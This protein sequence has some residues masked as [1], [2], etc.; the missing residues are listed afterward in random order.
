MFCRP[1]EKPTSHPP[2][3]AQ[4]TAAPSTPVPAVYPTLSAPAPTAAAPDP[5]TPTRGWEEPTTVQAPTWDDEPVQPAVTS[6]PEAWPPATEP[7]SKLPSDE[8]KDE[9][10]PVV[11]A[12]PKEVEPS[13]PA[14]EP[15]VEKPKAEPVP[16]AVPTL[17][18]TTSVTQ[19]TA[20]PS[21]KLSA[22]PAAASHRNSARYKVTDQ[23]VVMPSSFGSVDRVGM[24]FGSLN[25]GVESTFDSAPYVFI[26]LYLSETYYCDQN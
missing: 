23:P 13:T 15:L 7:P 5:E 12:K 9:P 22:R 6:V 21:P 4:Q 11:N 10:E 25:I 3:P 8:L 20:T 19:A 26:L 24:Q 2:V 17:A 16:Q 18:T 14:Q 1:Q